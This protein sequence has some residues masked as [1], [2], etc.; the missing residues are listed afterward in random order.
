[1]IKHD[2]WLN[3]TSFPQIDGTKALSIQKLGKEDLFEK[4]PKNVKN[5]ENTSALKI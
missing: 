4:M 3:G 5:D 2:F 1:M